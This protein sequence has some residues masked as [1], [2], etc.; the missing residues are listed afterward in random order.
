M[1]TVTLAGNDTSFL[2]QRDGF[3]HD[4]VAYEVDGRPVWPSFEVLLV[5]ILFT[6]FLAV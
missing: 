2:Y 3:R 1:L 4:T 6:R 5:A